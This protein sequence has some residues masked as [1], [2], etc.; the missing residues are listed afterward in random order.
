VNRN[1]ELVATELLRHT[2]EYAQAKCLLA[3]KHEIQAQLREVD[4]LLRQLRLCGVDAINLARKDRE[5]EANDFKNSEASS[6]Q[7]Q[8][9]LVAPVLIT[10]AEK[11]SSFVSFCHIEQLQ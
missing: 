3:K 6:M 8:A 10:L 1:P 2:P 7:S 11:I 9:T 5:R 4:N